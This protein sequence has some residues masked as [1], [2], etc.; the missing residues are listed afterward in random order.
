MSTPMAVPIR[1]SRFAIAALAAVTAAVIG[2]WA[3][4]KYRSPRPEAKPSDPSP[5]SA[6]SDHRGEILFLQHCASC[7]GPE[8]RGDGATAATL[9]PPPRDFAARPWR[10]EVSKDSI[11][12][13]IREGLPGTP[14]ASFRHALHVNDLEAVVDYSYSLA[15][16]RSPV[17]YEQSVEE[18]LLQQARFSDLGGQEVP[19]LTLSDSTGKEVALSQYHGQLVVLHFW[20]LACVHCV[21]DLPQ[22]RDMEATLAKR[23]LV[24]LHVCTDSDDVKDAQ[25][26]ADRIAPGIRTF[27]EERGLGL[28]RFE[29][30]S[31]PT[32]WLIGPDGMAIGRSHGARDWQDPA[33]RRVFEHWL[34]R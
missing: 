33:L 3:L 34:P 6:T 24:V 23:G 32:V 7:H 12:R 1:Q 18:N 11:R 9:R 22:L 25:A 15:T 17:P 20:G 31:L 19:P 5:R 30:Q 8:G 26:Q 28:A 13:V 21:K 4:G 10:F 27:A 16:S 2:G 14:M 29:V